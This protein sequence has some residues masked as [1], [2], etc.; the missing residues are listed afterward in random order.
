VNFEWKHNCEGSFQHLKNLLTISPI[1]RIVDPNEDLIICIDAC[2]GLGGVLSRNGYFVCYE[3]MKLKEHE[4]QYETHDLDLA[5]IVHALNM[6][7]NY[8]MG[9]IFEL[10][11][12]LTK[13]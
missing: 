10:C 3:S 6:C 4:R 11:W 13:F 7:S 2:K 12:P 5:A 8:L 9:K 1:M